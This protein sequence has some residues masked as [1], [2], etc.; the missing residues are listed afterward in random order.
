MLLFLTFRLLDFIDI[1]LVATLMYQIYKMIRGTVAINIFMGIFVVYLIW[2]I[3][4]ALNM[5]LLTAILGQ[6]MGVGVIALIIVFQQE[7]RRFLVVMTTRYFSKKKFSFDRLFKF[8]TTPANEVDIRQISLSLE[9]MS[10]TKTGAL[11]VISK[12]VDLNN[13]IHSGVLLNANINSE[14]IESI[15]F[16][17]NPL[18]DGAIIIVGNKIKAAK[19]ILPS[20]IRQ[21]LPPNYGTRHRAAIGISEETE[22]IT[23]LVSEETGRVAYAKNG[24]LH[25]IENLSNFIRY[26]SK[27][28]IH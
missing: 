15:F 17:N 5:Q 20:S 28:I 12:T 22:T 16:K 10:K 7:I 26:L 3:V 25:P 23:L 2:L 11:I 27:E 18:H 9:N 6:F 1:V 24:E 13:F 19:C 14:L 4:R 8:N 21:D